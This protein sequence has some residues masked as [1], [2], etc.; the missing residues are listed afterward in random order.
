MYVGMPKIIQNFMFILHPI[1][2][3]SAGPVQTPKAYSRVFERRRYEKLTKTLVEF[4]ILVQ[5]QR[6]RL[7]KTLP[8]ALYTVQPTNAT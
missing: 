1:F 4:E 5:L 6:M 8:L 3:R 7:I 2:I